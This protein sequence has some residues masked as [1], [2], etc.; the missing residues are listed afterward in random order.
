MR[1]DIELQAGAV[2]MASWLWDNRE[3]FRPLEILRVESK[4]IDTITG[5]LAIRL[6]VVLEDP[7]DPDETWP[8]GAYNAMY[9]AAL[10]RSLAEYDSLLYI[11]TLARST[12]EAA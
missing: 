5:E 3:Q 8:R 7:E 10:D 2:E 11:H 4:V 1:R 12:D 9:K 6:T